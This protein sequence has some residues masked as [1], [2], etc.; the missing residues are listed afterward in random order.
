[1]LLS[2][3]TEGYVEWLSFLQGREIL[4]RAEEVN[5]MDK[6]LMTGGQDVALYSL[7]C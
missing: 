4:Q 7:L 6:F 1:M 3:V 5:R 2:F